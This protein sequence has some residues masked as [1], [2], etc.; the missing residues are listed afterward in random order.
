MNIKELFNNEVFVKSLKLYEENP[1]QFRETRIHLVYLNKNRK[2][3]SIPLKRLELGN[4]GYSGF[5]YYTDEILDEYFVLGLIYNQSQEV[6][7]SCHNNLTPKEI[8]FLNNEIIDLKHVYEE[9]LRDFGDIFY[10]LSQS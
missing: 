2:I 1:W 9:D 7:L 10:I 8:Y 6:I 4:W 5:I 3:L